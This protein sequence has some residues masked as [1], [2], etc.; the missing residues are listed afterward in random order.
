LTALLTSLAEPVEA[1]TDVVTEGRRLGKVAVTEGR[2]IGKEEERLRMSRW[3]RFLSAIRTSSMKIY[4]QFSA[5]FRNRMHIRITRKNERQPDPYPKFRPQ[6]E[7][8]TNPDPLSLQSIRRRAASASLA[9]ELGRWTLRYWD[10]LPAIQRSALRYG[11]SQ[12]G[13]V[14]DGP[15]VFTVPLSSLLEALDVLRRHPQDEE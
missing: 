8:L 15:A 13:H 1:A 10:Q 3:S 6:S 14:G 11:L 7:A 4:F 5:V 9:L 2:R 12:G